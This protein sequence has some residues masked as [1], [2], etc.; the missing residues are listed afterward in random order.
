MLSVEGLA[1]NLGRYLRTIPPAKFEAIK[2][3]TPQIFHVKQSV[4][5]SESR[6]TQ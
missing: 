2:V 1:M 5:R 4:E 6:W 3:E